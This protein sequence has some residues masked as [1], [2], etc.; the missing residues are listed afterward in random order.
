MSKPVRTCVS[1]CACLTQLIL[2]PRQ[3]RARAKHRKAFDGMK[4]IL[5]SHAMNKDHCS[6]FNI[7]ALRL[8]QETISVV[9]KLVGF[10]VLFPGHRQFDLNSLGTKTLR[11]IKFGNKISSK[12]VDSQAKTL[13]A[14]VSCAHWIE[15]SKI[16]SGLADV[17]LKCHIRM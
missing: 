15:K 8:E 3:P 9:S 12:E 6:D 13:E 10:D 16:E 14:I 2:V 11:G 5:H 1:I 7:N 4:Y 17:E